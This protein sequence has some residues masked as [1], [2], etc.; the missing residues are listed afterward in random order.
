[1]RDF[2]PRKITFLQLLDPI[3]SRLARSQPIISL[4][5]PAASNVVEVRVKPPAGFL[6]NQGF[7]GPYHHKP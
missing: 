1:M 4:Q 3:E 6:E 2:Q 7:L 5:E